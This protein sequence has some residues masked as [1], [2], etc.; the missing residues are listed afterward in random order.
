MRSLSVLVIIVIVINV[1]S[2]VAISSVGMDQG[3]DSD[4]GDKTLSAF[5]DLEV[6]VTV[7]RPVGEARQPIGQGKPQTVVERSAMFESLSRSFV[8]TRGHQLPTQV[9]GDVGGSS[10]CAVPSLQDR[11]TDPR[12]AGDLTNLG[13]GHALAPRAK[14]GASSV[15][16]DPACFLLLKDPPGSSLPANAWRYASNG[17]L[18]TDDKGWRAEEPSLRRSVARAHAELRTGSSVVPPVVQATTVAIARRLHAAGRSGLASLWERAYPYTLKHTTLPLPDGTVYVLT[19]D[20]ELMWLRDSAAQ[21]S[22]YVPLV[23]IDPALDALVEGVIQRQAIFIRLDPYATSFRLYLDFDHVGKS[24]LTEWDFKS[25]RTIHVAMHNF[26]LDNLAYF[27]KLSRTYFDATG[28]V[29]S[30]VFDHVWLHAVALALRVM[31]VEQDHPD[32]S[33]YTYP[34]LAQNGRGSRVCRTGMVWCGHRPSDDKTQ[35]GYLVPSNMFAMVELQHLAR[36][37]PVVAPDATD[38]RQQAEQLARD[39]DD[40]I[41]EH[42]VDSNGVYAYEVDGCGNQVMMDDANLP[43]LL[44]MKYLG[45]SSPRH[46]PDGKIAAATRAF[47]LSSRNPTYVQGKYPGV[48][49]PHTPKTHVWHLALAAQ[50]LTA[51]DDEEFERI[52]E[53]IVTTASGGVVHEGYNVN[54]PGSFTRQSFAWANSLV[55]EL[56]LREIDRLAPD[57]ESVGEQAVTEVMRSF[58][59]FGHAQAPAAVSAA[60]GG[61]AAIVGGGGGGV[62]GG[63]GGGIGGRRKGR[64]TS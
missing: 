58:K 10:R 46:D 60:R 55:S 15:P 21:V 36:M 30:P 63:G 48:G 1:V 56:V 7:Q 35:L 8:H 4:V 14:S 38:L 57:T 11:T 53:Q 52:V 16:V 31:Q 33:I 54:N 6:A 39:I 29:A 25:E 20:I 59:N 9:V 26:E 37:L 43:S 23:G 24:E 45:F 3:T 64:A 49:S 12:L 22:Q 61:A 18:R 27:L 28:G 19:G 13:S 32:T 34:E 47:V 62:V 41:H 51:N 44:S 42:A 17:L 40:G 2:F 50:A 5:D